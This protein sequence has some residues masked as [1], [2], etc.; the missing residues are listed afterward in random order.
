MISKRQNNVYTSAQVSPHKQPFA[1]TS[2]ILLSP[3]IN[4]AA[5]LSEMVIVFSGFRDDTLKAQIEAKG[6]KVAMS[7]VKN[8]THILVKKGGK[9]SKKLDEAKEK[10]LEALDLEDFIA[11]HEFHL[12]E[13][14]PR[15]T[16]KKVKSDDEA[17]HSEHEAEHASGDEAPAKPI[18]KAAIAKQIEVIM[19][20]LLKLKMELAA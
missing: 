9:A 5:S 19:K 20:Q 12:G 3:P 18:N 1:S 7:L 17:E 15:A 6:G 2:Q 16:G 13:K 14:K 11:E 8:A 4:M 10:G